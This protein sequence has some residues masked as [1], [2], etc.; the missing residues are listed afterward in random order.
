LFVTTCTAGR[1][2]LLA[3]KIAQDI[4]E[5][6]WVKS[7]IIDGWFVG[8]YLLMPDHVHLFAVPALEAKPLAVWMKSWK[9]ISSR[10]LT[11]RSAFIPPIWQNDYFDHFV[12][13]PDAYRQK[14]E[15]VQ[16]NPVRQGLCQQSTAW[17]FQGTLHDLPPRVMG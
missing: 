14:W 11:A 17:P 15:Y 10:R 9:S 16:Q 6:V 3:G 5:E 7:A 1:R 13:N 12:R 2:P 4:L 8:Q